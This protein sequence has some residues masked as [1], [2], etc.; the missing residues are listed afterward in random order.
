MNLLRMSFLVMAVLAVGAGGCNVAGPQAVRR[1]RVDYNIAVQQTNVE[2][3][4]LNLVRLKYRD[5][6]YFME[7]ASIS[8]SFDFR[9]SASSSLAIPESGSNTY[10]LGSAVSYDEKPT[11]TYMPLQGDKFVK[12]VMSPIDLETVLLLY[13]SGWSIERIFRVCLQSIN[14]VKNMPSASGPTPDTAGEYAEFLKVCKL[15]RALQV[16]GDL[17]MGRC[18]QPGSDDL[19]VE[20]RIVQSALESNEARQLYEL[21][22]IEKGKNSFPITTEIYGG[23]SD[24]LAVVPRSLI[25]C[26]F[27]VSQAVEVPAGDERAGRVTVTKD[28]DGNRFDWQD[29]LG[30]LFRIQS[31]AQQPE[32]AYTAVK[33][34][35]SWFYIDDSNLTSK[36]TFV[37]L[38]QLFALQAG[39]VKS[40]GPI[41]TLPVGGQF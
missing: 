20:I 25:A 29:L 4:L 14:G 6:P 40:T 34:R 36:S 12:Q 38:M 11:I 5:T 8:T 3:M 26:F 24:R 27:Y 21:L 35:S 17:D 15:L 1:G 30:G 7:V 31:A 19:C 41:L 23:Q 22:K 28:T 33:Y 13:H 32:N 9:V 2:Q 39:E 18:K 10:G 16:R 37:L